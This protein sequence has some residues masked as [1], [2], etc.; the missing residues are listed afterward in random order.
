[1]ACHSLGSS[2]HSLHESATVCFAFQHFA[3]EV[4]R[5]AAFPGHCPDSHPSTH[6]NYSHI[7]IILIEHFKYCNI[8]YADK[9]RSIHINSAVSIT[10]K[11]LLMLIKHLDLDPVTACIFSFNFMNSSFI[12]LIC[13]DINIEKMPEHCKNWDLRFH[14]RKGR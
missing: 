3:Q 13:R 9:Y 2:L 1:M 12:I 5:R 8:S 11:V 14:R 7:E 4:S 10:R 6:A